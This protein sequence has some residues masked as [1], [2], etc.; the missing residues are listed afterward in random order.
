MDEGLYSQ[1]SQEA[2]M[3]FQA[4][5]GQYSEV[6]LIGILYLIYLTLHFLICLEKEGGGGC[7]A[8]IMFCRTLILSLLHAQF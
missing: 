3:G 2:L 7:Q 6:P 1:Y 8:F 5:N 4:E